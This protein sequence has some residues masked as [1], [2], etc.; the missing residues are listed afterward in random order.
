M[1]SNKRKHENG[2]RYVA[3]YHWVMKTDAWRDLSPVE[4]CAYVEIASRYR[5]PGSNNGTIP[6]SHGELVDALHI[7]KSTAHAA[8]K[9]LQEHGFIVMTRKGAFNIKHRHASEWLLTEFPDDRQGG[10]PIP[11]KDFARWEKT[12]H[13]SAT[14]PHRVRSPNRTG[15]PAEQVTKNNR[16]Y[17]SAT[18]P[19]GQSDGSATVPPLVYQGVERRGGELAATVIAPSPEEAQERSG[20][21]HT[22]SDAPAPEPTSQISNAGLVPISDTLAKILQN[23]SETGAR[24]ERSDDSSLA[25]SQELVEL[26]K[27]DGT[28][29]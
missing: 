18:V 14:V 23:Q 16:P 6:F 15:T 2:P 22:P 8:L 13:S 21:Q 9:S 5:G 11:T 20:R 12:K 4:R 17:G 19:V 1:G 26:Q 29:G 24:E 27:K 25:F 28:N 3:L 7:S 10:S